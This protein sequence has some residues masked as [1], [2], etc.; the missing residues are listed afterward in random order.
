MITALPE[1]TPFSLLLVCTG[2]ICRSPAAERL[3]AGEF[4]AGVTVSS[5]GTHALVG[6]PIS[7][8]MVPLIE[9]AGAD[10]QDFHARRLTEQVLRSADL[11]LAMAREHRAAVVEVWPAAVRRTFTLR[12]FAELLARVNPA[13]IPDGSHAAR[14]R[15]AIPLAAAQR[16]R[17]AFGPD[18]LDIADPYRR[19]DAH[20]AA[21]F[22]QIK[23]SVHTITCVVT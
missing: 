18:D 23:R 20:Y 3:L 10:P 22:A 4:D 8:P 17:V 21:A 6:K 1:P 9:G 5:A 2:N 16:G 14:L 13:Y 11:V 7:A 15:A 19:S 12:E